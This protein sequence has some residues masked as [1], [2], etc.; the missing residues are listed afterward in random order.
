MKEPFDGLAPIVISAYL[1]QNLETYCV[2]SRDEEIEK[3]DDP[4]F[5][6]VR[7]VGAHKF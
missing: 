3:G 4:I 1:W 5:M 7:N 6:K 2:H